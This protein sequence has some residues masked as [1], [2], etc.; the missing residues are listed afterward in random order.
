M[1]MRS[2][3]H[4]FYKVLTE[5]ETLLRL[6]YYKPEHALDDPLSPDKANVLAMTGKQKIIDDLIKTTSKTD[7]L[8][9]KKKARLLVYLGK[10]RS[11]KN[12]L[13]A[14]QLVVFDVLV[15]MDWEDKD[16]RSSWICDRI[17]EL[18]FDKLITGLGEVL[19]ID[20][21]QIGAPEGFVGYRLIY[22]ISSEN[23]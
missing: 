11:T 8:T 4:A 9:T 1:N 19:F 22:K 21:D 2:H 16:Q 15:A 3:F 12:Y 20:G 17:N 6:L 7:D 10:R 18:V 13:F 5:D 23:Y 14:N